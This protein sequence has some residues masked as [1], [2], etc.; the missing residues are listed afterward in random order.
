MKGLKISATVIASVRA[1][2]GT[3]G[4]PLGGKPS[5]IK[6]AEPVPGT[7]RHLCSSQ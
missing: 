4:S 5:L 6:M 1:P 7:A 2:N 3:F